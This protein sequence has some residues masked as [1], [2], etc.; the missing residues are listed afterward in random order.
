MNLDAIVAQLSQFFSDGI[1]K[2]IA[3]FLW[4]LYTILF[5]ANAPGAHPVEI[6]N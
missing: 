1:G 4:N 6:P 2:I 5:P 3:D